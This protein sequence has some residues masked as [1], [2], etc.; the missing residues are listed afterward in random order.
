MKERRAIDYLNDMTVASISI[1]V[2]PASTAAAMA[3]GAHSGAKKSAIGV[4]GYPS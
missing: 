1:A 4:T 3:K 2:R